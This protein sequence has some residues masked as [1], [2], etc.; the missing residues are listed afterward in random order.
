MNYLTLNIR[1][2]LQLDGPDDGGFSAKNG[3]AVTEG[4]SLKVRISNFEI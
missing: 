3:A 2:R 1:M 4:A